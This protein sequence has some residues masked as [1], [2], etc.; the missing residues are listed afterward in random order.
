MVNFGSGYNYV[1]VTATTGD[2][3]LATGLVATPEPSSLVLLGSGLLALVGFTLK[4]TIAWSTRIPLSSSTHSSR[5]TG[6]RVLFLA[7][8]HQIRP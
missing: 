7:S 6:R 2:V 5:K 1:D 3:L 8:T 4:K